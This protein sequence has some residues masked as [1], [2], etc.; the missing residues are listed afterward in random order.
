MPQY[1]SVRLEVD[2]LTLQE[3][4]LD[5]QNYGTHRQV[6]TTDCYYRT[7]RLFHPTSP[8]HVGH[9]EIDYATVLKGSITGIARPPVRLVRAPI[10]KT[11]SVEKPE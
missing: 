2:K 7:W 6:S 10:S 5:H 3:S 4:S 11:K 9:Y 8:R 1:L